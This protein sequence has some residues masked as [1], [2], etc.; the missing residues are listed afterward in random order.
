MRQKKETKKRDTIRK[1]SQT[2]ENYNSG[3]NTLNN[4]WESFSTNIR[5][6]TKV[7][8]NHI[9]QDTDKKGVRGYR[10]MFM[11]DR[12]IFSFMSNSFTD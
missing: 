7:P 5:L 1:H 4:T 9:C 3:C 12:L 10:S 2:I 6:L 8:R 11:E